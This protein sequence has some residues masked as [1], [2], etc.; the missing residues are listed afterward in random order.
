MGFQGLL[1]PGMQ[2]SERT[3]IELEVRLPVTANKAAISS[4][5][6]ET[7]LVVV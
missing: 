5:E 4:R 3:D 6:A 7:H 1:Q 2:V